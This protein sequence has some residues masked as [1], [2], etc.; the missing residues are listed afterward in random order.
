MKG[1]FITG[2]DT[3]IGKTVV[4]SCLTIGLKK[5]GFSV[6]PVKPVATGGVE[7]EGWLVSEDALVYQLLAD[8]QE[9]ASELSPYCLKKPA[10]PHLAA[11]LE[12]KK[13]QLSK[14]RESLR[15]LEQRYQYLLV[16][17][18]GGWKVPITT[19]Y[20]VSNLAVDLGL[21]VIV[22]AA[23]RLGAINHTLLTLES[24]RSCEIEPAGVIFTQPV[25]LDD[26]EISENNIETVKTLGNV[27]ILGNIPFLGDNLL[28][29]ETS[30]SLW[31]K[32]KDNI[33]WSKI[34]QIFNTA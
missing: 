8:V 7:P 19:K 17:G 27:K 28:Q 32:V 6:C 24:I 18:I 12:N 2:T 5:M 20:F 21:P 30:E 14:I 9:T 4:T 16:E 29:S 34:K 23:N 1:L 15:I 25:L 13:F 33:Q 31:I 3:G 26:P 10:S 11:K 22:A